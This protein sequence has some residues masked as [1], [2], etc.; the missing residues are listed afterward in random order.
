MSNIFMKS[1]VSEKEKNVKKEASI[2]SI[3]D[4]N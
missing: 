4:E 2:T 1:G 3:L